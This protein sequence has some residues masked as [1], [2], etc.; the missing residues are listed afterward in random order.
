MNRIITFTLILLSSCLFAQDLDTIR[1]YPPDLKSGKLLMQALQ[2]RKSTRAYADKE[3]TLADLS[4]LLWAANGINRPEEGKR[5]APTARNR[6]ELD[7]YVVLKKGIYFYDAVKSLL[8]PV[9]A[10]D[11][12]AQAGMQDYVATAPVNLIFVSDLEK[13]GGNDADQECSSRTNVG[14][15]SQNVYLYC[16]SAGLGTVAWGS[17]QKER[18]STTMKLRPGQMIILAQSVGYPK[19]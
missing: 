13:L 4:N 17:V 1:L 15:I 10:G 11:Y 12:R 5:T 14:Y 16:A 2:E 9:A 7:I 19:E 18:L 8:V 3:L 6:Q